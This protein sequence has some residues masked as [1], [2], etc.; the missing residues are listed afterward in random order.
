[1]E[2]DALISRGQVENG[3]NRFQQRAIRL[4]NQVQCSNHRNRFEFL[5]LA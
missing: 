5:G 3:E 4:E 1:M 2:G